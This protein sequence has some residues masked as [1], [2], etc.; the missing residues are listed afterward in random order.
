MVSF[1]RN[2]SFDCADPYALAR[3]WSGVVGHPVHPECGP[4]DDTVVIEPPD[5]PR[6]FFQAVPESKVA[7][8]RMHLCLQPADTDRDGEVDR[9]LAL[10]AT[11]VA[12]RRADGWAVL[13]DPAGNEFCVT[14]SSAERARWVVW[15]QDD[16]GNRF[17]VNRFESREDAERLAATMETR[18][19]KQI[20]WVAGR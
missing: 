12:D 20:Y 19:H 7:K 16:N 14:R 18:G 9:L 8:N 2:V 17:E 13:A 4:G 15:R 3:F 10:G 5:G 11:M 6:L 1:I